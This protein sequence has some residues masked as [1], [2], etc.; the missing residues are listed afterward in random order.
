[1]ARRGPP[2]SVRLIFIKVHGSI[3][4]EF[5]IGNM[6]DVMVVKLYIAALAKVAVLV[7]A[8]LITTTNA[9]AADIRVLASA[10]AG[11]VSALKELVPAFERSAGHKVTMNFA[12]AVPLKRRIDG[13]EA[14]DVVIAPA[15]IDDLV[16]HGKVSADTRVVL[17]YTGL[18]LGVRKGALKPDISSVDALKRTLLNA[19]SVGT[20]SQ[21]EP[22]IL[23]SDVLDKLG[24][25][26][27]ISSKLKNLGGVAEMGT[28]LQRQE[29]EMVVTSMTNL[30]E[31]PSAIDV[32]GGFPSEL[33]KRIDMAAGVNAATKEMAAAK[34]LLAFLMSPTAVP[35]F[36]AKGFERD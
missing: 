32:V 18:A 25:A 12:S 35:T 30:L 2:S 1:M 21:S 33:R 19:K 3:A 17:G 11:L 34:E 26:Q 24:I 20:N 4:G 7:C 5:Y 28:A 6:E 8:T 23:F 15:L 13:G 36:K 31:V 10:N 27:D 16:K 29:V 22:G 14:F 9:M